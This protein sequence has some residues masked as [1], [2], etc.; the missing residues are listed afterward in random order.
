MCVKLGP[1]FIISQY[2]VTLGGYI[3]TKPVFY[4]IF[5]AILHKTSENVFQLKT[6]NRLTLLS[7]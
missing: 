7:Q 6:K 3:E 2:A 5:P 4:P 1:H